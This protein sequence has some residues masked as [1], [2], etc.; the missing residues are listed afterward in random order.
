MRKRLEL[1]QFALG[2]TLLLGGLIVP[3]RNTSA[4]E[5]SADASHRKVKNR[6]TPDYPSLAKQ[7]NVTGKVKV[8]TTIS[9]DGRVTNT[10]VVGGSPILVN[11]AIDALRKWRFE[12]APKES[13]EIIEFDFGNQN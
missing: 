12:S 8:E 6:V 3:M 4:Q 1:A 13:T 5:A 11:A 9:P 7:M 10:K 2:L